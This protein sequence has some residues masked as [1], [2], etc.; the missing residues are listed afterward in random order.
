M[1]SKHSKV[2]QSIQ[3][4]IVII[5]KR[6]EEFDCKFYPFEKDLKYWNANLNNSKGI[7]SIR[8]QIVT[9]RKEF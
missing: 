7:R 5:R 1:D 9:I 2:I 3:I 6:F 4:K 8:M